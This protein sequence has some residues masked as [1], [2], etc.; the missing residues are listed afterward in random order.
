MAERPGNAADP[1]PA[2][3]HPALTEREPELNREHA[4]GKTGGSTVE[5]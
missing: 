1:R 4:N 2:E 5:G 3:A